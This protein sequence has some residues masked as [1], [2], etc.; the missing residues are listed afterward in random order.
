M[1][2]KIKSRLSKEILSFLSLPNEKLLF[3][4]KPHVVTLLP[5]LLG[6]SIVFLF[7]IGGIGYFFLIIFPNLSLFTL[8][9]ITILL[10]SV[11][12]F[13]AKLFEWLVHFYVVTDRKII[14]M[15][16]APP[17]SHSLSTILLD[18]VRC[19]EIDT[20]KN[21]L[22]HEILD[23]GDV[24]ITFDRP[25]QQESFVLKDIKLPDRISI[26][27]GDVLTSK[28]G[29]GLKKPFWYKTIKIPS[30]LQIG[31]DI[32]IDFDSSTTQMTYP[33]LD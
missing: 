3:V 12:A 6:I 26:Y 19:T 25:T 7:L 10:L 21:G 32:D 23:V 31:E 24:T 27:L 14:E 13:A 30:H 2:N 20:Q 22:V 4:G 29:D 15:R 5:P 16:Y 1:N 18:Q 8:S 28:A 33:R 11:I 9:L 17:I